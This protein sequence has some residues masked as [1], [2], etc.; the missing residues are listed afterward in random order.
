M[1]L[2]AMRVTGQM[3]ENGGSVVK[4]DDSRQAIEQERNTLLVVLL[5]HERLKEQHT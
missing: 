1:I 5:R 3:T 4:I 2:Q